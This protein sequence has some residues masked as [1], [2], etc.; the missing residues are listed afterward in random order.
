MFQMYV[1]NGPKNPNSFSKNF[2]L[3]IFKRN[4]KRKFSTF[5]HPRF[6]LSSP[7]IFQLFTETSQQNFLCLS[8]KNIFFFF[9]KKLFVLKGTEQMQRFMKGR[10]RHLF[11]VE[12]LFFHQDVHPF[13]VK[14]C[15]TPLCQGCLSQKILGVQWRALGGMYY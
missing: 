14:L 5:L 8:Q 2:L 12:Q 13:F 11:T 10:G 7:K 3:E 1:P 4:F 6:Y 15:F 9:T